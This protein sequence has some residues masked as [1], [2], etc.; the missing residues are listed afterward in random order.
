MNNFFLQ[1]NVDFLVKQTGYTLKSI[2]IE[3]LSRSALEN[4][5]YKENYD[6]R[7][8]SLKALRKHFN[9]KIDDLIFTDL[10]KGTNEQYS[11]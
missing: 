3:G 10:S 8:S 4:I 7:L 6:L 5:V 2:Q 9:V 1:V 11:K